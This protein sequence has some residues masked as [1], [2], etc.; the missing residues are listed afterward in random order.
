MRFALGKESQDQLSESENSVRFPVKDSFPLFKTTVKATVSSAHGEISIL[1]S[2]LL[3][4][5]WRSV[6]TEHRA[7]RPQTSAS[8]TDHVAE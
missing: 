5:L 6:E 4:G 3:L 1:S 7:C 8:G 2:L